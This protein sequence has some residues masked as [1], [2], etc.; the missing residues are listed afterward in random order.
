M[1][2]QTSRSLTEARVLELIEQR[3]RR[4]QRR[5]FEELPPFVVPADSVG[6]NELNAG[7]PTDGYVLTADS[8]A[9]SGIIWAAPT[10]GTGSSGLVIAEEPVGAVDGSNDTFTLKK[11]VDGANIWC[12]LNGLTLITP[13]DFAV[14]GSTLTFAVPPLS[15]GILRAFYV[16]GS[17]PPPPVEYSLDFSFI[18][19]SMYLGAI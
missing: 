11:S 2:N 6:Q 17:T 16:P 14:S 15:G 8:E 18:D 12:T 10:G 1:R 7:A 19:N 4:F 13:E 3:V 9:G 5:T